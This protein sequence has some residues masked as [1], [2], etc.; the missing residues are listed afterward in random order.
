MKINCDSQSEI[1]LAKNPTYHSN[2]K[3]IDVQYHFLRDMV[4]SNKVLLD[5]LNTLENIVD[6]LTKYVSTVNFSWCRE[7]MGIVEN[8][9]DNV[10]LL[11][12][13]Q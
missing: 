5:K 10:G 9:C 6:S 1:F 11:Y 7:A 8:K 2:T 12:S 13:L 3:N 4:E